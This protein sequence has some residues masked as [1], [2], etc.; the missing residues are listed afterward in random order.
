MKWAWVTKSEARCRF[1][2]IFLFPHWR[3]FFLISYFCAVVCIRHRDDCLD[4]GA[5]RTTKLERS[6]PLS[7]SSSLVKLSDEVPEMRSQSALNDYRNQT[8]SDVF[9]RDASV[10]AYCG[11]KTSFQKK[12][13]SLSDEPDLW[14]RHRK[15][16]PSSNQT[17]KQV[18]DHSDYC[19]VKEIPTSC[20]SKSAIRSVT[21]AVLWAL[22]S[23]LH[24]NLVELWS[25][26]LEHLL[27]YGSRRS[28]F[29]HYPH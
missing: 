24:R 23:Q 19:R 2:G 26:L 3:A 7:D 27:L 20:G 13:S 9:I 18:T 29:S 1:E 15:E 12:S 10:V 8:G 22:G 14:T 6:S 28:S 16:R 21:N 11:R 4:R 25:V 5:S 17:S